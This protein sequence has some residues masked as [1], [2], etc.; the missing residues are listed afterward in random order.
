MFPAVFESYVIFISVAEGQAWLS[1]NT[2]GAPLELHP[3]TNFETI[4]IVE[5]F[6]GY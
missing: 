5:K 6:F 1:V 2:E 4:Y 3:F